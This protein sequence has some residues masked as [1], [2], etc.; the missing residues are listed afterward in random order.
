MSSLLRALC[1]NRHVNLRHPNAGMRFPSMPPA[2]CAEPCQPGQTA[3]IQNTGWVTQGDQQHP[4]TFSFHLIVCTVYT[5][6]KHTKALAFFIHIMF[7]FSS[8]AQQQKCFFYLLIFA[9]YLH[10]CKCICLCQM[11]KYINI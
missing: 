8:K 1:L 4:A 7:L 5:F 3:L 2:Y 9:I 10:Q 11:Y 6:T